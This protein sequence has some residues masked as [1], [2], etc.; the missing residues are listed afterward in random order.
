ML[1]GIQRDLDDLVTHLDAAARLGPLRGGSV[2]AINRV[3]EA[4][5]RGVARIPGKHGGA[6]RRY[7]ELEVL[8]PDSPG[9]M[10]RLFSELGEAGVSIED[11]VLEHSSGQQVG[12]GRVMID[13]SAMERAVAVLEA[14][15][16]RLIPH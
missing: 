1:R 13:P 15:S 14:H 5:N 7:A 9:E 6:P 11:F 3:M 12:V 10:G 16:W 8:I 2:G 4:G